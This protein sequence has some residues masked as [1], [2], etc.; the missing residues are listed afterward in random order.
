MQCFRCKNEN[1]GQGRFCNECGAPLDVKVL[2]DEL[3]RAEVKAS[4]D[5]RLQDSKVIQSQWLAE[6]VEKLS[7]W[8]KLWAFFAGIPLALFLGFLAAAGYSKYSDFSSSV[9]SK[10]RNYSAEAEARKKELAGVSSATEIALKAMSDKS[11]SLNSNYGDLEERFR[12]LKEK[13]PLYESIVARLDELATKQNGLQDQLSTLA[14]DNSLDSLRP[15][16]A[17]LARKLVEI[18]HQKGIEVIV[19]ET[20]RTQERQTALF[21]EGATKL[22]VVGAHG[23]GLAFDVAKKVNC[24]PSFKGSFSEIG[25]IGK[26]LG[27]TWGGD[28]GVFSDAAHFQLGTNAEMPAILRTAKRCVPSA[29]LTAARGHSN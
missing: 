17:A 7:N 16:V 6:T 10:L 12:V 24:Q 21:K 22:R 25:E 18:A 8:V 1:P 11:N 3:V 9:D 20:C 15:E 5:A 19:F 23:Y 29:S 2:V 28:Q 14:I 4:L 13:L 27:L 26:S